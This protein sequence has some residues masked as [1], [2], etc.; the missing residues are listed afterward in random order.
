[1]KITILI[2]NYNYGRWLN[3]CIRSCLSQQFDDYEIIIVDDCSNDHSKD[4]LS[5]YHNYP[6]IKVIYNQTNVGIGA[7]C[8]IGL[9][10]ALGFYTIRVDADDYIG[11]FCLR[12]LWLYARYNKSHAV[13]CDY[14]TIDLN[15]DVLQRVSAKEL[16]IACGILF[17]TDILEY[18]GSYNTSKRLYEDKELLDRF[19][20]EFT[21]HYLEIPF[22]KY[23][24]HNKSLTSVSDV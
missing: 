14:H 3:R 17:R 1:M 13:A 16:P 19:N 12:C 6:N 2:T 10:N 8:F 20:K 23:F 22:Y 15:E 24:K 11:E 7:S 18:L 21:M 4:I 5:K 9:S